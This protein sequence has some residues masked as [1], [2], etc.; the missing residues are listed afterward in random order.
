MKSP[1]PKPCTRTVSPNSGTIPPPLPPSCPMHQLLGS[2]PD[3]SSCMRERERERERRAK[4]S[5]AFWLLRVLSPHSLAKI[6]R[7]VLVILINPLWPS[8]ILYSVAVV[9]CDIV[10]R[11]GISYRIDNLDYRRTKLTHTHTPRPYLDLDVDLFRSSLTYR[12]P[13]PLSDNFHPHLR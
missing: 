5:R 9:E 10:Y 6:A 4:T 13:F 3:V 12:S 8:C 7:T 2:R 11:P 1:I